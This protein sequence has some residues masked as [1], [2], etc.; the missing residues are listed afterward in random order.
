MFTRQRCGQRVRYQSAAHARVAIDGNGNA[1]SRTT[2][3]H[4]KFGSAIGNDRGQLVAIVRIIHPIRQFRTKVG[5]F[6]AQTDQILAQFGLE[7]DGGVV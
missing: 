3:G 6:M 2:Q 7:V 1:N 4:A 5:N